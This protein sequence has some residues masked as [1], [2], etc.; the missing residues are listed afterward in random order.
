MAKVATI[1]TTLTGNG[2]SEKPKTGKKVK[3][4]SQKRKYCDI[5]T[6]GTMYNWLISADRI[7][8]KLKNGVD[9]LLVT[10]PNK[11]IELESDK[12]H[13]FKFGIYLLGEKTTLTVRQDSDDLGHLKIKTSHLWIGK[14][15]RISCD[16]LGYRKHSGPGKGQSASKHFQT[17]GG[18]SYGS[19]GRVFNSVNGRG[20]NGVIYGDKTLLKEIYFGSGGGS[21]RFPYFK[22]EGGRGGGI[23]EIIVEQQIIN[24]G[25]IEC[26]GLRG[27]ELRNYRGLISLGVGGGSGGGSGGSILVVLQAPSHIYQNFGCIQCIDRDNYCCV[28]RGG[29]GRIAI[30]S[31]YFL[32]NKNLFE[33]FS[34]IYTSSLI[35]KE[36]FIMKRSVS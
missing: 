1:Q 12:W 4:K 29:C 16:G 2:D 7:K 5:K 21:A 28:N 10:E 25:F 35:P 9:Y 19:K 24:K 15:C 13:H 3:K 22:L 23:I 20:K 27:N 36:E 32:S 30:Y 17:G 11:R 8:P 34:Y 26:N 33:N 31:R 14:E 18:A 6:C